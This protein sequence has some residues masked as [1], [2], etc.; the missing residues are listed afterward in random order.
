[1][2]CLARDVLELNAVLGKHG[3]L[4]L[5]PKVV[6]RFSRV[7]RAVRAEFEVISEAQA[8]ILEQFKAFD[9]Q[10]NAITQKQP[11]GTEVFKL[12]DQPAYMAAIKD[13]LAAEVD[14]PGDQFEA[15]DLIRGEVNSD[16]VTALHWA[17]KPESPA[18][19]PTP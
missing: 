6:L 4:N 8:K 3:G 12:K 1:V 16:V 13:L 7:Q 19:P 11:D 9:A 14:I 5:L 18:T 2:K 17:I 15:D 10:G